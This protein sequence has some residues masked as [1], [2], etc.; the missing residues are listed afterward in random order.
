LRHGDTVLSTVRP[1]RGSYFL[2]LNPPNNRVVSTGFAVLTPSRAPWS[3]VYA[4]VTQSEISDHLGRMAD[5][6]AY[7]AVRPEI[8]GAM[9]VALP[10]EPK[11]LEVFHRTCA[12]LLERAEAN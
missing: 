12:P 10:D 2:A 3:F 7:P 8:I 11:I 9:K 1:D 5:G 6:G 4:A